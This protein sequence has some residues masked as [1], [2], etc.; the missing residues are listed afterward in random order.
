MRIRVSRGF[1]ARWK[2]TA[3]R[4]DP[5]FEATKM[6]DDRVNKSGVQV[7]LHMQCNEVMESVLK[8]G[9]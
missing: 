4:G 8:S 6:I 5:L 9:G 7:I 3:P 2:G 1:R